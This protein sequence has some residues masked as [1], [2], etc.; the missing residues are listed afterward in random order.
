MYVLETS[1]KNETNLSYFMD[2]LKTA[3]FTISAINGAFLNE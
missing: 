1:K 3:Y 2:K